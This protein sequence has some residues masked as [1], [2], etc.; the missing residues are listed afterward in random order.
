MS[1]QA[2]KPSRLAPIVITGIAAGVLYKAY[3]AI[4]SEPKA[5]QKPAPKHLAEPKPAERDTTPE[6]AKQAKPAS[7]EEHAKPVRDVKASS[8]EDQSSDVTH[9][10]QQTLNEKKA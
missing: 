3:K 2:K 5:K 10:G 9:S 6:Q 4:F 7:H 8:A 1:R